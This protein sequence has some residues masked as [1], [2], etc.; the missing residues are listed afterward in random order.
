MGWAGSGTKFVCCV[1]QSSGC[2]GHQP[3]CT[4]FSPKLSFMITRLYPKAS[5]ERQARKGLAEIHSPH[6]CRQCRSCCK[7]RPY[8][9]GSGVETTGLG[10]ATRCL[11]PAGSVQCQLHALQACDATMLQ[12]EERRYSG[13]DKGGQTPSCILS[14]LNMGLQDQDLEEIARVTRDL[15][16]H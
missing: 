5:N 10:S 8:L 3:M 6:G 16:T 4:S 11:G 12:E 1:Q 15:Q 14:S 2:C 7:H 13:G 9:G